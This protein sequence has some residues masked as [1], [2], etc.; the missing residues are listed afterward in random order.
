MIWP[1]T[2]IVLTILPSLNVDG[3]KASG[4]RP[5][6]FVEGRAARQVRRTESERP[7]LAGYNN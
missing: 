3:R 1:S 6:V 5:D 2:T 7:S 4:G